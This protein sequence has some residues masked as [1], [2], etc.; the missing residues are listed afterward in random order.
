MKTAAVLLAGLAASGMAMPSDSHRVHETRDTVRGARFDKRDAVAATA[1][2]PLRIALKQSNLDKAA[3]MLL[4][5]ST[6]GSPNY[7]KHLSR[8]EAAALFAVEDK[9]I[10][11]IKQWL[12]KSGVDAKAISVNP[13]KTW[14][15]VNAPVQ[16]LEKMLKTRYHTY[17]NVISGADHVGTDQYSLPKEVSEIVDFVVPG[18]N[19]AKVKT[20]AAPP[21]KGKTPFAAIWEGL[22]DL[23]AEQQQIVVNASRS[24][25]KGCKK[26]STDNNGTA[27]LDHCDTIITPACIQAIYGIPKGVQSNITNPMGFFE[28]INDVYSQEDL[29]LFWKTAAPYVPQGTGPDLDL[30]NGATAPNPPERA[31]GESDLDFQMAIPIIYPETTVLFQTAGGGSDDIFGDYLAAVDPDFCPLDPNLNPHKMCGVFQPTNVVSIS[32]GGPED[33][34]DVAGS[35]RLCNEFM[36]LGLIGITTVASSGDSGVADAGNYCYGP[37]HDIFVPDDLGSCPYIT[38]VGATTLPAGSKVGDP[39]IAVN[40]YSGGGGFSN[41][42]PRPSW[43]NGAVGNYLLRHNPNYFAYNTSDGVIPPNSGIYNRGGR[44]YP[45]ISALG[46]NGLVAYRGKLGLSGGTSMS[47]PIIGAIFTRINEQRLSLGKGPIG[48][49]N[50]ALYGAYDK[51]RSKDFVGFFHDV[52]VGN[53]YLGGVAGDRGYSACGNVGFSC[54]QGWDPVT[55][56]GTPNYPMWEKYFVSL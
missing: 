4:D 39:E 11:T 38:S 44:A 32:Y 3:A 52:T 1:N 45:D 26:P 18:V 33:P 34:S 41:I 2:M 6:P 12:V 37:H 55:G 10:D 53:Q 5:I 29:D 35:K 27:S 47:A 51:I 7:G 22:R 23:T 40:S 54:V 14:M 13:T 49:V 25:R 46:D 42:F 21:P 43:Q 24:A 20:R 30:I 16:Q 48:W 8:K 28:S 31:G 36:K 50:P 15:T 56:L 19:L 17:R 9:S